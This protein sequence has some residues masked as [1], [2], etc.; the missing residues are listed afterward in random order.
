MA[1]TT[2]LSTS[3][4][5][6]NTIKDNFKTFLQSQGQFADYDFDGSNINVLL[7]ILAYNTYLNSFYLNM[8]GSEMFLDTAQ[9][10]ES[11]VSH[12]KELNYIPRSRASAEALVNITISTNNES[13]DSV[14]I[15]E[16]FVFTTTMDSTTYNFYVGDDHIVIANDGVYQA[17]NVAIYEGRLVTEYFDIGLDT[18]LVLQSDS[19][20]TRSISVTVYDSNTAVVG[21]TYTPASSL[22]GLTPTSNVFFIHGYKS[23]QYEIEFGSGI[24]GRSVLPGNRVEVVYRSTNGTLGNG[25]SSFNTNAQVDGYSVAVATVLT[26]R[27]GAERETINNIKFNAPRFFNTQERA[28][29]AQDYISLTMARFPQFQAVAAYGGERMNP[30]QYGK[31]AIS[32][33]PYGKTGTVSDALKSEVVG[34]L[35]LKNLTTEPI[36]VDPDLFYAKITTTVKYNPNVTTLGQQTIKTMVANN[37]VNF[38]QSYLNDFGIDFSYSKLTSSIDDT[39]LSIIGNDTSVKLVK[40]WS[41][42]AQVTNNISFSYYNELYHEATLYQLPQGHELTFESSTFKYVSGNNTYDAYLGDDGLGTIKIYTNQSTNNAVANSTTRTSLND[43]A[44]SVNYYTGDVTFTANV[45]SYVGAYIDLKASLL[46][47]DISVE[48]NAFLIVSAQDLTVTLVPVIE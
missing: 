5:D 10:K 22:F 45:D 26:A 15:P 18:S 43:N 9:L 35:N 42:V 46:S 17:S 41:P 16:N 21:Y 14:V 13:P 6:F 19:I 36:I 29:T 23:N 8:V 47:K 1:N 30:P 24:T 39:D 7:D 44:G 33:K 27:N 37:I 32:L 40:R 48:R 2:F 20:D 12:A 28:V 4:L 38:G 25:A 11:A 3:E 31:V 34:F